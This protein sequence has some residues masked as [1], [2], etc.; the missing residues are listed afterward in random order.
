MIDAEF[1][2][3]RL[4]QIPSVG[5]FTAEFVEMTDDNLAVVNVGTNSLELPCDG[6]YPPRAGMTVRVQN[7]AGKLVVTGPAVTRNNI[8]TV[9][10]VSGNGEFLTVQSDGQQYRLPYFDSIVDPKAGDL[11]QIDWVSEQ[12]TGRLATEQEDPP[13]EEKP[14]PKPKP[15]PTRFSGLLVRATASGRF[16]TGKSWGN[17]PWGSSNNRGLWVYGNRVRDALKGATINKVEIYLP[18]IQQVGSATWG[19]A[20]YRALPGFPPT[21]T[22]LQPMPSR[23]GWVTI[24]SSWYSYIQQGYGLGVGEVSGYNRWRGTASDS[25]SGALRFAGTR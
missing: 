21:I 7:T 22:S 8:G 15:G 13:E 19:L 18:L 24:P 3:Q 6:F 2:A 20:N 11:V 16:Q 23:S 9:L 1:V 10:A 4:N 25:L 5:S 12:V 17:D 14:K